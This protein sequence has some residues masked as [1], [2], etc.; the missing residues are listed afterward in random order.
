M[1]RRVANGAMLVALAMIFGYVEVLIPFDFMVPGVKLGLA[2]LVVI[3]GIYVMKWQDVLLVSVLRIVL[4]AV[5]FGNVM[6]LAYSFAGAFLS[7]LT[8]LLLKRIRGLSVVTV[9]AAGGVAHN[10]G[11]LI[12]AAVMV[13]NI[14]VFVYFP[15]LIIAGVLTG[16]V[17]GM[18]A[19]RLMHPMKQHLR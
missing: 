8:M 6:T 11:Q 12:A 2:N 16:G 3:S 17:I 15:V 4:S 7:F 9:S 10:I 14:H 13:K 1:G 18:L 5:L 19:G